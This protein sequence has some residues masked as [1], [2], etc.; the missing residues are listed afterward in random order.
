VPTVLQIARAAG[1]IATA[2]PAAAA[3]PVSLRVALRLHVLPAMR[4]Q[5]CGEVVR[6]GNAPV[7][8]IVRH[9]LGDLGL[10][11][12]P[13]RS[14]DLVLVAVEPGRVRRRL[15]A[16]RHRAGGAPVVA[17]LRSSDAALASGA[18]AAGAHAFHALDTSPEYL[19]ETV[20]VLLALK[21]ASDRGATSRGPRRRRAPPSR[22]RDGRAAGR[23]G[24]RAARRRVGT[25]RTN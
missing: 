13:A 19:R 16:A 6:A 9:V 3:I 20:L 4:H 17:L 18:L 21:A 2:A 15:T 23:P 8:A 1:H 14:P 10:R 24:Q 12:G 7:A 5:V 22:R 25:E 11:S